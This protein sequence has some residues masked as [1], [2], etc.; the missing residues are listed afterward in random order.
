M[1]W[2]LLFAGLIIIGLSAGH[3]TRITAW[4][5]ALPPKS[6]ADVVVIVVIVSALAALGLT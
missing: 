1:N 4:F 5:N 6:R 2:I 3:I